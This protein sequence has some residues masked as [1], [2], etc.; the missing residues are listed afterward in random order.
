MKVKY[1]LTSLVAGMLASSS[2]YAWNGPRYGNHWNY[3]ADAKAKSEVQ[4]AVM[5]QT[6]SVS[7]WYHTSPR[8]HATHGR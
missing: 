3:P 6:Q 1:M 7:P 4:V 2:A 5:A 8:T